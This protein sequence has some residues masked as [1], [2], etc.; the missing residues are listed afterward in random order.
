MTTL[1]NT[2]PFLADPSEVGKEPPSNV[3]KFV[4]DMNYGD[5]AIHLLGGP[6]VTKVSKI[7]VAVPYGSYDPNEDLS[8]LT[9]EQVAKYRCPAEWRALFED[10]MPT[11]S[12]ISENL[13]KLKKMGHIITPDVQRVF[14]A[15]HYVRPADAKIVIIG[16]DPYMGT[17]N[18]NYRGYNIQTK[19]AVGMAFSQHYFDYSRQPSLARIF[20]AIQMAYSP[21]PVVLQSNDLTPWARQGVFLLNYSLTGDL[22]KAG[23]HGKLWQGFITRVLELI[24]DSNPNSIIVM[25]G[26][27]AQKLEKYASRFK[28]II[29]N[30]HPA[31]RDGTFPSKA[32]GDFRTIWN[33]LNHLQLPQID[34]S[35]PFIPLQ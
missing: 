22:N 26:N 7:E 18:F 10:M 20:E 6:P 2:I 13:E 35:L 16:Q 4:K 11:I 30:V 24:N 29:K 12:I 19:K 15:F 31:V 9:L 5:V 25:W 34:W 28:F 33:I 1:A 3:D 23:A 14:S 21:N 32:A 27:E 17:I 8:H